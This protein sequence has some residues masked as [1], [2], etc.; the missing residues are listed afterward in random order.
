MV[1]QTDRKRD[2]LQSMKDQ[3]SDQQDS[4]ATFRDNLA[5]YLDALGVIQANATDIIWP[6]IDEMLSVSNSSLVYDAAFS[7][8][9]HL[10][11]A[12]V[13]ISGP[14]AY[15]MHAL[16]EH[17]D[18]L[19]ASGASDDTITLAYAIDGILIDLYLSVWNNCTTALDV[20]GVAKS[21]DTLTDYLSP[22]NPSLLPDSFEK[23]DSA[24]DDTYRIS[25]PPEDR[26][27]DVV[28]DETMLWEAIKHPDPTTSVS[29]LAVLES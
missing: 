8:F 26:F 28:S 22:K 2:V 21:L 4:T 7:I 3:E 17:E 19:E 23:V 29:K 20:T 13:A 5:G 14:F 15:G 11:M 16:D 1:K 6:F 25:E 18:Q 12:L 27:V 9:A 10:T 24:L